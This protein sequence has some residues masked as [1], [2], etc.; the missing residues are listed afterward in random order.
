MGLI[1][2]KW[3]KFIIIILLLLAIIYFIPNK[4]EA[5][6]FIEAAGGTLWE[7][8]QEFL[9]WVGDCILNIMQN[10]FLTQ[11]RVAVVAKSGSEVEGVSG[12]SILLLIGSIALL[13]AGV[14]FAWTGI[15]AAGIV[16]GIKGVCI[17]IACVAGS[18]A[19]GS[20]AVNDMADKLSGE[21]D[22]PMIGYTPYA[23]FSNS[24]PALD[25]NFIKPMKNIDEKV[26]EQIEEERVA[27]D[28]RS[29]LGLG[30]V[31]TEEGTVANNN[32]GGITED[33]MQK[34]RKKY[35]FNEN[36]LSGTKVE[37]SVSTGSAWSEYKYTWTYNEK[38]Y[39]VIVGF[40]PTGGT[41]SLD[42]YIIRDM[43]EI[44][45]NDTYDTYTY[46]SSARVLQ[47]I[48]SSWY[49]TLRN[50]ALVGLLSILVYIGIRIVLSSTA[51]EKAKYKSMIMDW[52]VAI[53][54]IFF[55]HYIMV[56]IIEVNTQLTQLFVNNI[57]EN[58]PV[59]LP[60]DTTI[61]DE[62]GE[63]HNL[64]E[65]AK[66][67]E[68]YQV[69]DSGHPRLITNFVGYS[70]LIAGGYHEYDKMTSAV[71][72][73]IYLVLVIYTVI[74]TVVYLKRVIYMAFLTIV[75]PL[76]CLTYPIDKINDGKAQAFNMWLKEYIFNAL[77]QPIHLLIYTIIIGSVMELAVK[78]P[79]YA[80]VALGFMVPAEKIVRRFFGF[81][82]A[83]TPGALGGAAGAA[84]MMTGMQRLLHKP[85][86]GD[87]REEEKEDKQKPTFSPSINPD[88]D[89][90]GRGNAQ[91]GLP[92]D[93]TQ[94]RG[95]SEGGSYGED[96]SATDTDMQAGNSPVVDSPT[97][98]LESPQGSDL[99]GEDTSGVAMPIRTVTPD[100]L[101]EDNTSQR[102]ISRRRR[103][104]NGVRN[105]GHAYKRNLNESL[106]KKHPIR[107]LRKATTAALGG[108]AMGTLGLAA[109][110]ASGDP[111]KALQ[112]G[113]TG[114]T[115]GGQFTKGLGDKMS[116]E[117]HNT[118]K[119][120]VKA[121]KQGFVRTKLRKREIY[122]R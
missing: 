54:L 92:R 45:T 109:G 36:N 107:T 122:K 104:Y 114:A 91:G 78:Y 80:L 108:A 120:G 25:I 99:F 115:V 66:S 7:P 68:G 48:V 3:F 16:A 71:Y 10:T 85:P 87:R 112:Y 38:K 4:S 116:N 14:A 84:L 96:T 73:L 21:F 29:S 27:V 49:Y 23:I 57:T 69:S 8:I 35:G 46:E 110:I 37:Q 55:L 34:F 97:R 12:W 111:S 19:M 70:R 33:Q 65:T 63:E 44:I 58:I 89:L 53:C 6:G 121:F 39:E 62:S 42:P 40:A 79:V 59:D 22:I 18:V 81:E 103:F 75:S 56:F 51:N 60:D 118:T 117:R 50:L 26:N 52:V 98:T 61:K 30:T 119:A 67:K 20:I 93:D 72:C 43:N 83:Q 77:L 32:S 1:Q 106:K 113:I 105:M 28:I 13:I 47:P 9:V 41:V 11:Q 88:D 2:K 100:A 94:A 31:T 82:K 86:H 95:L 76:V 90:I 64:L 5:K 74:F 15:G 101:A 102:E 24:I 17:G